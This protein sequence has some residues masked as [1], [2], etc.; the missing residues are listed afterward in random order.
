MSET[1]VFVAAMLDSKQVWIK[2]SSWTDK[3]SQVSMY[4]NSSGAYIT[5]AMDHA[6]LPPGGAKDMFNQYLLEFSAEH[7]ISLIHDISREASVYVNL[8]KKVWDECVVTVTGDIKK[9]E[10][11][12]AVLIDGKP[13]E[14]VGVV[15]LTM[16]I[17]FKLIGCLPESVV[18]NCKYTEVHDTIPSLRHRQVSYGGFTHGS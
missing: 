1:S 3:R 14:D 17:P 12:A 6:K 16:S 18:K 5:T 10:I 8:R 13:I 9:N 2:C 7:G 4:F 11:R 15:Q